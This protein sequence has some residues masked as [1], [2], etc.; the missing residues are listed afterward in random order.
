LC[1]DHTIMRV[2]LRALL[3]AEP[4]FLIIGEAS[5]G[6]EAV[7]LAERLKPLVVVLDVMMPGING[8]EAARQINQRCPNTYIVFLSMHAREAYVVEA[9]K[10]GAH[11]YVLKDSQANDLIQAVRAVLAG[12]R[13]L[14]PPLSE[15]SLKAYLK[16]I[17]TKP[18]D[19]YETLTGREREVL[20]LTAEGNSSSQIGVRLGISPRTVEI[21]RANMMRKLGVHSQIEVVR[22]AFQRGLLPLET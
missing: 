22:Y 2:G 5:D 4:D 10:K 17:H 13:Y 9:F 6:L 19:L 20:H 16:K 11:A 21:H 3:S 18:L 14:S 12:H 15:R 7:E 1:D 8:L